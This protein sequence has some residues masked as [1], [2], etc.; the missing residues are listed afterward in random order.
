MDG[1]VFQYIASLGFPIVAC[2]AM[3]VFVKW[4]IEESNKQMNNM[5]ADHKAEVE[6]MTEAVNNNTIVLQQ[7]V[8]KINLQC[9]CDE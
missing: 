1:S 4:Q 5:R 8:D 7:L 2:V 6:K 3:G 9:K